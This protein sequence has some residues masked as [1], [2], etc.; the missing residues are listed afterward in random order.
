M[1]PDSKCDDGV[2]DLCIAG[3]VSR[4]KIFAIDPQIYERHPGQRSGRAVPPFAQCDRDSGG[5][6]SAGARRW[7]NTLRGRQALGGGAATRS[8]RPYH[9][10]RMKYAFR[11]YVTRLIKAIIDVI[12]DRPQRGHKKGSLKRTFDFSLQSHQFHGSGDLFYL[13]AAPPHHRH[14]QGGNLG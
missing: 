2:F 9:P 4:G 10:R 8:I 3:E 12:C 13:H 14:R 1:A 6:R 5:G 7:R 11:D